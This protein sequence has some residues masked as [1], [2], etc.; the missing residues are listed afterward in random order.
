[1]PA[2]ELAQLTA[3]GA[4]LLAA[5]REQMAN[6]KVTKFGPVNA[7][8]RT[9]EAMRY[10]VSA[11]ATGY[12]LQLFMPESGLT[13]LFGRQP[14]KFPP[15]VD[16]QQWI[17]DR[18]IVPTPGANGKTTSIEANAQGYSPLAY[19]FARAIATKGNTVH[20]QGP[21]S[22]LFANLISPESIIAQVKSLL[23]PLFIADVRSQLHAAIVAP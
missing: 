9:S 15:L 3:F 22:S 20:Q 6:L 11:T 7:S 1:M 16:I 17:V 21:P 14:G 10:E 2:A 5:C 18:G 4:D 8:K 23:L 12:R 13:L 19:L